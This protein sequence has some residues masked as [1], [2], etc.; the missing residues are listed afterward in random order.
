MKLMREPID[1]E[2]DEGQSSLEYAL[3]FIGFLAI[4][5][6]LYALYSFSSEDV[7]LELIEQSTSHAIGGGGLDG[8]K[9]I[10]LY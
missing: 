7:L 10:L 3:V 5:T 2:G 4:A 6:A 8:V 1:L 9:D